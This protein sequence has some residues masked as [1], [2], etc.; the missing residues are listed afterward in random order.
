[1]STVSG[2]ASTKLDRG[3]L[4]GGEPGRRDV[5]GAPCCWTR[6]RR[7]SPCRPPGARRPSP[8]DGR[9]RA[10]GAAARPGT[11]ADGRC[12]R[13]PARPGRRRLQPGG[14]ERARSAGAAASGRPPRGRGRPA[15]ATTSMHGI[16]E[17]HRRLPLRPAD[18]VDQRRGQVLVGA[19]PVGVT[20]ARRIDAARAASRAS[21]SARSRRRNS[22][23]LVSASTCSPGL[24]VLDQDQPEVGQVELHRVDDADRDHL[25]PVGQPGQR[26]LPVDVA[27]EV[28]DDEDQAAPAGGGRG[29]PQ[30]RGEVGGAPVR[31]ARPSAW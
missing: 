24:G 6:R 29:Q 2:C 11:A 23:S 5:V 19:D 3:G 1:M 10:A 4:R 26:R 14:R 7:G 15:T 16:L 20:P 18:H 31:R 13:Q 17:A 12:R 27:D 22:G 9:G 21:T 28:G 8:V 30:H 25:V